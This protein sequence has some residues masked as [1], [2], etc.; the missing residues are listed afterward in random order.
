M[1]ALFFRVG[2]V[3]EPKDLQAMLREAHDDQ[4]QK[5]LD[6]IAER[7]AAGDVPL[8]DGEGMEPLR[9]PGPYKPDPRVDGVV[10]TLRNLSTDD[11]AYMTTTARVRYLRSR[12]DEVPQNIDGLVEHSLTLE[13]RARAEMRAF[14]IKAVASV[15]GLF[16]DGSSVDVEK[17]IADLEAN[18]LLV[19]LFTA[20]RRYQDLTATEKK[21]FGLSPRPTSTTSI[22]TPARDNT[23]SCSAVTGA[24]TGGL[25]HPNGARSTPAPGAS[26]GASRPTTAP[27]FGSIVIEHGT[28]AAMSPHD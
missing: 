16:E 5:T 4:R 18:G 10:V 23:E 9:D 11:V 26:F 1:G 7:K 24:D 14:V 20:A 3:S 22:V 17:D 15:Q 28:A 19:P 27:S 12:V 2:D 25:S 6:D 13:R 21:T 8:D